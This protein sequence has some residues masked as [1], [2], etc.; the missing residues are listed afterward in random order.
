MII[1][2]KFYMNVYDNNDYIS[3]MSK[4]KQSVPSVQLSVV[5]RVIFIGTNLNV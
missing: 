3:K 2:T 4:F 1:T 5:E